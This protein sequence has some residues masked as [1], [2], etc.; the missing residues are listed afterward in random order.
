VAIWAE[1]WHVDGRKPY[2]V[3]KNGEPIPISEAAEHA[4]TFSPDGKLLAVS[5]T[6]GQGVVD[7][8]SVRAGNLIQTL[9]AGSRA[10]RRAQREAW[11]QPETCFCSFSSDGSLLATG[12]QRSMHLWCTCTWRDLP[13]F[14]PAY[15]I[16]K[17]NVSTLKFMPM[18]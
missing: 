17:G 8:W 2:K 15:R 18:F 5:G 9:N 4:L 16:P 11:E 10:G 6:H 3:L 1:L 12:I 7:V 14:N 13:F